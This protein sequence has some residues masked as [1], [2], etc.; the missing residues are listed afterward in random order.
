M[1][2]D[3]SPLLVFVP[4]LGGFSRLR[5][6]G[7]G[8][9]YFRG[10]PRMLE[11]EGIRAIFPPQL[12]FGSVSARADNL[13][14]CVSRFPDERL[15]FVAH[16]MG[17]LDCRH[18]IS[19]LDKHHRAVAL[20]TVATP[21]RGTPLADW[22][23]TSKNPIA[24]LGRT[25]MRDAIR[26]LTVGACE[27]FNRATPD[28]PDVQ[29]LSYSGVRPVDENVWLFRP[30]V[31]LLAKAAG[32]NDSQVPLSS[33]IWGAHRK[34]VRSDHIE[35]TGWNFG[36]PNSSTGRPFDHLNFYRQ[37]VRESSGLAISD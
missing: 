6:A 18:Y 24:V 35:L 22:A 29:Y 5:F 11:R 2:S 15:I 27:Q 21:H 26:D 10:V 16:S 12:P 25:I 17:G 36:L 31:R 13:A 9:D 3:N 33:A 30:W 19:H 28:R 23:M 8:I 37:L 32:D 7:I 34:T 4:G 14:V 20:I 1:S